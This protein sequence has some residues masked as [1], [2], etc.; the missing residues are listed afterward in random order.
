MAKHLVDA[1]QEVWVFDLKEDTHRLELL[2]DRQVPIAPDL[3]GSRLQARLGP[4]LCT[5]LSGG[6]AETPRC[7]VTLR[8]Q[9]RLDL[10]DLR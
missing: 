5:P 1:G 4:I 7:F 10:S 3:D 8:E 2:L 9:G 6:I